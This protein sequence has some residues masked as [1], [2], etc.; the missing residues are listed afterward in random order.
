MERDPLLMQQLP[1]LQNA[2]AALQHDPAED[3]HLQPLYKVFFQYLADHE[4]I[5]E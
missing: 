4:V 5:G 1:I 3:G 2:L